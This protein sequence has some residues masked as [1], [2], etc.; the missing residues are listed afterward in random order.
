M[1]S[2]LQTPHPEQ[3]GPTM[4]SAEALELVSAKDLAG[5]LTEQ[6]RDLFHSIHQVWAMGPLGR[7]QTACPRQLLPHFPC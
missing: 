1:C 4:G 5:Q 3:L 2:R 6:D 7:G